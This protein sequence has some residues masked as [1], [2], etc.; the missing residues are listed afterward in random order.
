MRIHLE[1]VHVVMI[2]AMA[3]FI[4]LMLAVRFKPTTWRAIVLQAIVANVSATV[5]VLAFEMLL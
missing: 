5:T 4:A 2:I 3:L 1:S